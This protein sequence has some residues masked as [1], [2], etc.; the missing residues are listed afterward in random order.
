M[1]RVGVKMT[2]ILVGT[3]G[4]GYNKRVGPVYLEG[5]KPAARLPPYFRLFRTL[6]LDHIYY[7]MPKTTN[8]DKMLVIGG[9]A[10]TF[11]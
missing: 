5:T 7:G 1:P 10:L 9:P 6:E 2:K 3:C 4:Y 11:I 8:L